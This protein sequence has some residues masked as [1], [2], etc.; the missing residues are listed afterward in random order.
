MGALTTPRIPRPSQRYRLDYGKRRVLARIAV[1]TL[2][3]GAAVI[4]GVAV[5]TGIAVA[6]TVSADASLVS[7]ATDLQDGATT[8]LAPPPHQL[9]ALNFL[10]G[11]YNCAA[12]SA[13]GAKPVN[14]TWTTT[15]ILDSNY[16]QMT[17]KAPLPGGGTAL[18]NWTFGWD[19]IDFNYFGGYFDS[20]GAFGVATSTGWHDGHF[21]F[22]GNYTYVDVS[23]GASGVGEGM[24]LTTQDDFTIVGPGHFTDTITVFL[25]GQ[26][27]PKGSD[28]CRLTN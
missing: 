22:P 16:Y 2:A 11:T 12:V 6:E 3:A 8:H 28:D 1:V 4:T 23:G 25:N 20:T 18:A 19:S 14:A 21:K 7:H 27:T 17:I 24:H 26:W 9:T 13:P 5:I 15:K 10:L